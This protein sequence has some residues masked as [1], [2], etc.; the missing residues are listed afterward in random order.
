MGICLSGSYFPSFQGQGVSD[1]PFYFGETIT[2]DLANYN[3]NYTYAN[4]PQGEYR[5]KTTPVGS[6]PPNAFGLYDMHGNIWEW[7]LDT[8]H[9]DCQGAPSDGNPWISEASKYF[10]VRGGSY[11]LKPENCRSTLRYRDYPDNFF[12]L[13][14]FRCVVARTL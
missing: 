6:F 2:T 1:P 5:K 12:N 14:G 13:I 8:W 9:G 11:N 4:E 3:G 7:C 10:V